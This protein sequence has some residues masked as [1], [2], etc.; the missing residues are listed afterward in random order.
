MSG[1]PAKS[2]PWWLW[3]A[4]WVACAAGVAFARHVDRR[5]DAELTAR[6]DAAQQVSQNQRLAVDRVRAMLSSARETGRYPTR[7]ELERELN[8]GA[9]FVMTPVLRDGDGTPRERAVY[10]D[11]KSG[12][13]FTLEFEDGEWSLRDWT[14]PPTPRSR[15]PSATEVLYVAT[16]RVCRR[17]MP[18]CGWGWLGLFLVTIP[19][20]R[21]RH[22]PSLARG[23]L[24][25]A[26]V[27]LAA[28]LA[29]SAT[30][31]EGDPACLDAVMAG[32]S[33]TFV[34][35]G[36]INER[37]RRED[38]VSDRKCLTCGYDLR[39]T[40]D[41]CPECGTPPPGRVEP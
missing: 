31:S 15:A 39:A 27:F 35:I 32:L 10:I 6:R 28:G 21:T 20:M 29:Y 25:A 2:P 41:R 3:A 23:S 14:Y 37:F 30:G 8:G 1:P 19:M 33:A 26:I 5:Y 38:R 4:L 40:P 36:R 13:S 34:G 24:A 17:A 7:R 16:R 12:M 9:P 22:G 18:A 11:P